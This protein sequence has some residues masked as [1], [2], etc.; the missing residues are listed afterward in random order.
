[1]KIL[2]GRW[3]LWRILWS[4]KQKGEQVS[5]VERVILASENI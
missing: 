4:R 3:N 2:G 5:Q 1:M